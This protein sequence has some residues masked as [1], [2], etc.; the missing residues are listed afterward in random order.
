MI[1]QPPNGHSR[2]NFLSLASG[3]AIGAP[4]AAT[5]GVENPYARAGDGAHL[6]LGLAAYS[7]GR[8]FKYM[9]GK[10][11]EIAEPGKEI[12][13]LGFIDFCAKHGVDGAELTSYFFP[14]D[15]AKT[16]L[17]AQCRHRAHISGV[18][19]S[20]TAVGNN[21]SYPKD[22]P[23]RAQQME[24]VKEW[25]D[26]AAVMG[27]PHIRV[28]AGKHPK[29]VSGEEAE[30]NAIEALVEAAEYAGKKGIFLGIENH[31]SIATADRLLRIVRAVKS[32]WVSV[33]LDTG[34]FHSEDPYA[35]MAASAPYSAN[36]QVK[37][38]LKIDGKHQP[39]D[40]KR[41]GD[42]LKEANYRGFVVLEFEEKDDPFEAVPKALDQ[43]R[44]GIA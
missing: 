11:R 4:A 6:R 5:F 22:A 8:Y 23:E 12:D 40:F 43:L 15:V 41:V 3:F 42:I 32:P 36:V 16:G 27:A 44:A 29:G 10:E 9:K 34:N 24:Y 39:T 31:D 37:V 35:D 25:I 19:V 21:F 26:H 38:A 7:F 14:P 20:G 33:N 18:S 1:L 2:R 13:M 17:L 30:K 28:F